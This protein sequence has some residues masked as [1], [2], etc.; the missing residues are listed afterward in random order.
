M[1]QVA[2]HE[3]SADGANWISSMDV[4][5]RKADLQPAAFHLG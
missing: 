2:H 5:L 3:A 1:T 4:T